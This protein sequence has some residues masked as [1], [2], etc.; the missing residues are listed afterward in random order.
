M[1]IVGLICLV[2]LWWTC[3]G[4][5]WK[6]VKALRLTS[7][8]NLLSRTLIQKSNITISESNNTIMTHKS[9]LNDWKQI[10][11]KRDT[12]RIEETDKGESIWTIPIPWDQVWE[13]LSEVIMAKKLYVDREDKQILLPVTW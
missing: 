1:I 6:V 8:T 10:K 4:W 12:L 7:D 5:Q 13:P 2:F 11:W 9:E 3:I